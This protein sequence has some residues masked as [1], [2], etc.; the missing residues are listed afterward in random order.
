MP[1][2]RNCCNAPSTARRRSSAPS[3]VKLFA[4]VYLPYGAAAAGAGE[5]KARCRVLEDLHWAIMFADAGH[6]FRLITQAPMPCIAQPP[7][8]ISETGKIGP[9]LEVCR[10][11]LWKSRSSPYPRGSGIWCATSRWQHADT[12]LSEVIQNKSEGNPF[13]VEGSSGR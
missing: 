5:T 10:P 6:L 7:K 8:R 3:P 1:Y 11:Y 13:F 12:K 9:A 2:W 4:I